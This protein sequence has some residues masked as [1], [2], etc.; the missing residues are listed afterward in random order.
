MK[1]IYME[2]GTTLN[3]SVNTGIQ[4]VVR[5]IVRES[6]YLSEEFGYRCIKVAFNGSKICL[7]SEPK[8]ET[9]SLLKLATNVFIRLLVNIKNIKKAYTL[10]PNIAKEFSS[11]HIRRLVGYVNNSSQ[12]IPININSEADSLEILLLLDSTWDNRIWPGVDE[13]RARGGHVCAVLYDLIPFSH[14]KTVE[15]VTRIAHTQWWVEAPLHLDSIMCISSAV[16]DDYLDWQKKLNISRKLSP[17]SVG[18]FHLGANLKRDDPVIE[19][20]NSRRPSFLVVGSIE[21]RKNHAFILDAF[22]QLWNN[23]EEINLVIVGGFGWKCGEV[24]SRIQTHPEFGR[25]LFLIKDA[26]DRDLNRLYEISEAII[27]A[28]LAE[29]FGLPIVEAL[30]HGT[31]VICSDIPVFREIAGMNASYFDLA[32]NS[33]L[34]MLVSKYAKDKKNLATPDRA[35]YGQWISWSESTRQ[36][37]ERMF[38]LA[39]KNQEI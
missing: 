27:I 24:L 28:S 6:D 26:S 17:E 37:F 1:K 9:K 38:S 35:K 30:Y 23:D 18:Y 14:P 33:E 3:S 32:C 19:V 4:R 29:G 39:A 21:P 2:C 7:V 11:R 22:D 5:S 10:I 34:A 36:L 25:R 12:E 31:A 16:R 13:F 20:F 8:I 15:E